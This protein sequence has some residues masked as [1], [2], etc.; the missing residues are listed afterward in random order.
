MKIIALGG[1]GGMGRYAARTA[2]TYDFVDEV[3]IAELDGE[4]A[5]AFA[6]ADA[7]SVPALRG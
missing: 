4:R 7:S 3:V 1:S 5:A 2:V 6:V